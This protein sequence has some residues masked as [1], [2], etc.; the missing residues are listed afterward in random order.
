M[1]KLKYMTFLGLSAGFL[2][3]S[4]VMA[5]TKNETVYSKLNYDGT[6]VKTMVTN[7]LMG[8]KEEELE[9]TA[10]LFDLL[11]LNKKK[12]LQVE[13]KTLKWKSDGT[14]LFY[15][16]STEKEVDI[17]VSIKYYLDGEEKKANEIV[18]QK[19]HV[20]IVY[21][22]KNNMENT[23]LVGG[24][25]EILY[26]P[27]V[28]TLGTMIKQENAENVIIS[29]GKVINNGN[30]YMVA[31]LTLPGLYESLGMDSLKEWNTITIEYDTESCTLS[32]VYFVATPKL[33]EEKDIRIFDD[34]KQVYAN[35]DT[36]KQSILAIEDG[37]GKLESGAST[38]YEGADHLSSS[39]KN[40]V[41]SIAPLQNGSGAVTEGLQTLLNNLKEAN[42]MLSHSIDL[43][44]MLPLKEKNEGAILSLKTANASL[45]SEYTTNQLG[46][47]T[48]EQIM[49]A[50]HDSVTTKNLVTLKQ[51]YEANSN[52]IAL[53]EA[54]NKA[55]ETAYTT[56]SSLQTQMVGLIEKLEEGTT[57]LHNGSQ[58][59]S[60]GMETLK[61]G[62]SKIYA[63]SLTLKEGTNTLKEGSNEVNKGVHRF[64]EEGI[65]KLV[66]YKN[67]LQNYT[68]KV[69]ALLDLSKKYNGYASSN[70]NVTNFI[71]TVSSLKK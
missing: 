19:G 68:N 25:K 17:A 24:R 36:L 7:Q 22:F 12:D 13:G 4:N 55:M 56:F 67:T 39:L 50:G 46:S 71:Y 51:T 18:G 27:F 60:R 58:Q 38:L 20:K 3:T 47:L 32:Q 14:S 10:E 21:T 53:L 40:V 6:V 34:L 70:S 28:V 37:T 9:D 41:A 62:I 35:L 48:I 2:F 66:S 52:L 63:G 65:S 42:S 57:Q 69:D 43:T 49:A 16:G 30:S 44:S 15:Q 33:I 29:N 59:V 5:Y 45:E 1:K 54:N 11:A 64:N 23:V 61:E 31:G 8:E 26:T